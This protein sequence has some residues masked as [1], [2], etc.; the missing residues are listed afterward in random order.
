MTRPAADKGKTRRVAPRLAAAALAVLAGA[1]VCFASELALD[2]RVESDEA[3]RVAVVEKIVPATIAIFDS[4]GSGG[5]SGVIVSPEGYAVTNFHVVAPCGPRMKCGLPDGR[6][7]DAVMVGL[8]PVGDVA[9]IKLLPPA[10]GNQPPA[11]PVAEWGDSDLVEPGDEAI[12]AGNPFLLATDFQ[13]TVTRGIISG[14][15]RYQYPSGTLLEYAD[16]LQTDASINPGN[17]GGP[18]YNG[19]GQLIGINGR[20]SFEKRGRVNVGVGYAISA[21]QVK[22]FLSHLLSGRIVDHASLG[23]TVRSAGLGRVVVDQ[24]DPGS[25]AYRRGLRVGDEIIRFGERPIASANALQNALGTYP[26]GWRVGVAYRR[27]YQTRRAVVRLGRLHGAAQLEELVRGQMAG[28]QP[29][30]PTPPNPDQGDSAPYTARA[31]F[32]NYHFNRLRLDAVLAACP[33]R[34]ALPRGGVILRGNEAGPAAGGNE[35]GPAAGGNEAGPAAAGAAATAEASLVEVRLADDRAAFSAGR[36]RFWADVTSE[37]DSQ[38]APPG[39]GGM[40]AALHLWRRALA[41][42]PPPSLQYVG[43]APWGDR[44]ELHDVLTLNQQS[45]VVDFYFDPG[46]HNLVAVEAA[47]TRG[48]DACVVRF[49]GFTHGGGPLPTGV[50]I[51]RGDTPWL[52]LRGVTYAGLESAGSAP[53]GLPAQSPGGIE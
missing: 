35:A 10:E 39:S 23:A 20:G 2:Q 1:P 42:D 18:L 44:L 7:V 51:S 4:G 50:A 19:R 21:N 36:G 9:V 32:A 40:L 13:P 47:P 22:R 11:W 43:Q 3:R 34:G 30:K 29:G 17:S 41:G 28:T 38:L 5:G 53:K 48:V 46:T 8:D 26:P 37:L 27:G 24:I 49:T 31:G 6:F 45:M 15:H 33:Q 16:C 14:T 12:V 52:T 25:D